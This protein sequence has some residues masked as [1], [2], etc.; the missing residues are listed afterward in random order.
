ML[1]SS[2]AVV[3]LE[4]FSLLVVY[5]TTKTTAGRRRVKNECRPGSGHKAING[6]IDWVQSVRDEQQAPSKNCRGDL[7]V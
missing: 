5:A 3:Y 4:S 2:T 6:T 7:R 1:F